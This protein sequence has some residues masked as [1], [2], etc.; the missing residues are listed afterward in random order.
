[1]AAAL[2]HALETAGQQAMTA[3]AAAR[4]SALLPDL[5]DVNEPAGSRL[6]DWLGR[7]PWPGH[8]SRAEPQR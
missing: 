3:E 4:I 7:L 1:M 8:G 6:S 2:D 5:K